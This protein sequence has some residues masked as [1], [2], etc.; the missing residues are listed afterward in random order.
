[1]DLSQLEIL[2]VA[3]RGLRSVS[4]RVSWGAGFSPFDSARRELLESVE[5][6]FSPSANLLRPWNFLEPGVETCSCLCGARACG[7]GACAVQCRYGGAVHGSRTVWGAACV[8]REE[9]GEAAGGR[10]HTAM[11]LLGLKVLSHDVL[12]GSVYLT[13]RLCTR[14]DGIQLALQ[15][16]K[17]G[18][19]I[20][21]YPLPLPERAEKREKHVIALTCFASML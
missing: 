19:F 2:G 3:V 10:L 21:Q 1:M 15:R 13:L 6:I 17:D 8:E 4:R 11:A 20:L 12:N 5:K 16:L 18:Q 7:G 14:V 9:G